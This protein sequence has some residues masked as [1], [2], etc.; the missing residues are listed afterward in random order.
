MRRPATLVQVPLLLNRAES[1]LGE[2]TFCSAHQSPPCPVTC[3]LCHS[4]TSVCC[5]T[6]L[7]SLGLEAWSLVHQRLTLLV[8]VGP[9]RRRQQGFILGSFQPRF[10]SAF[11]QDIQ[12]GLLLQLCLSER[13]SPQVFSACHLSSRFNSEPPA[14]TV[15]QAARSLALPLG[16]IETRQW[17]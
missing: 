8:T 11:H 10:P 1:A 14:D 7:V 16:H 3:S 6:C 13:L 15:S 5:V 4:T 12:S 17:G 2:T 9:V